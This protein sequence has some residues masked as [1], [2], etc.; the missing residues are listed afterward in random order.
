MI[1]AGARR[2]ACISGPLDT[3]TGADRYAGYRQT[4]VEAGRAAQGRRVVEGDF[5]EEGGYLAARKLLSART[6][7]DA[8]FVSN[9]LMTIGALRALEESGVCI[10]DDIQL[11]A[12]DDAPWAPLLKPALTAVSQPSYDIGQEAARLL[13][14]RIQGYDGPAREVVLKP[15]LHVRGSTRAVTARRSSSRE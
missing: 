11:V 7:P 8:L 5:H 13:L 1:A 6:R 4:L 15:T 14:D 2:L 9:N 10:P 3:T 12:F